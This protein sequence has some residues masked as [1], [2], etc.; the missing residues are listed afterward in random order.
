MIYE[1]LVLPVC[2]PPA[3]AVRA[4]F[5][6]AGSAPRRWLTFVCFAGEQL[7]A[8]EGADPD[9]ADGY[10][11]LLAERVDLQTVMDVLDDR[12]GRGYLYELGAGFVLPL[13]GG[14]E[15]ECPLGREEI[16]AVLDREA[17]RWPREEHLWLTYDQTIVALRLQ[18]E[19]PADP[20]H[21]HEDYQ[22]LLDQL[23][24]IRAR[25]IEAGA[26]VPAPDEDEAVIAVGRSTY[27]AMT[28]CSEARAQYRA[29]HGR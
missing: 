22:A 20:F 23:A 5:D 17:R 21:P 26:E 25:M 14:G 8:G 16:D 2:P 15:R 12:A 13:P 10:R 6:R 1:R 19:H 11:V 29:A 9:R 28:G 24:T 18:A 4:V 7:Q 27:P 3:L